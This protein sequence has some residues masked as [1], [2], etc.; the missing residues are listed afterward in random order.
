MNCRSSPRE[1]DAPRH[2]AW[3]GILAPLAIAIL[4]V[5]GGEALAATFY[6]W[7]DAQGL[8]H[9]GDQPPKGFKGEVTRIDVDP[10][11]LV[12]PAP[13]ARSSEERT[14]LGVPA[15]PDMLE[16]RRATRARLDENLANARARLDVAKQALAEFTAGG[17]GQVIQQTFDPSAPASGTPPPA[18]PDGAAPTGPSM[19]GMLGMSGRSNC[20]TNA[21]KTVTC[22]SLVPNEEYQQHA[23]A[24][25]DAVK[26]AEAEVADAEVAYR[27]GVD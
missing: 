3:L 24:L 5:A 6:K 2:R 9:Y 21:N 11:E 4:A 27:K 10:G 20:H 12:A 22:A 17:S 15:A 16:Q 14:T 18:G 25:E 1:T 8:V 7:T 23:T 26:R 19:G 13:K